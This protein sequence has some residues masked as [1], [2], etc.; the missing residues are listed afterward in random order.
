MVFL[1]LFMPKFIPSLLACSVEAWLMLEGASSIN[2]SSWDSSSPLGP[3]DR[4]G[5]QPIR[6]HYLFILT[7]SLLTLGFLNP[8]T[9][10]G[11]IDSAWVSLQK[12]IYQIHQL[13]LHLPHTKQWVRYAW[14]PSI[15]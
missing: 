4:Q 8:L 13:I 11:T 5:K 1:R 10:D 2:T 6:K 12:F 7:H 15:Q 3:T 9:N 14:V